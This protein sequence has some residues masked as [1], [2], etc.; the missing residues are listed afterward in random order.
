MNV[1]I[2]TN[3][4]KNAYIGEVYEYS[5]DFRNKTASQVTNDWWILSRG[6]LQINTN[7]LY[8]S[9]SVN[10]INLLSNKLNTVLATAKKITYHVLWRHGSWTADLNC[11][12]TTWLYPNQ[13]KSTW[14]YNSYSS[15]NSY[16]YWWTSTSFTHTPT[17]WVLEYTY[18][19]DLVAKTMTLTYQ[20]WSS[21]IFT[22]TMSDTAITNIRTNNYIR[23]ILNW[24][25][26]AISKI[27]ILVE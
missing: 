19:L 24:S 25:N 11:Q 9:G 12:I 14:V 13:S 1:Y 22:N 21:S 6:S 7:G 17:T 16:T 15:Y 5:Y 4:L 23:L 10:E 8:S 3:S 26:E 27:D 20:Q 2:W 18:E